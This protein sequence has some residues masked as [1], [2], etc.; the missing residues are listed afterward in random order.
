MITADLDSLVHVATLPASHAYIAVEHALLWSGQLPC[1]VTIHLCSFFD[2]SS[3]MQSPSRGP[4]S[5]VARSTLGDP[6]RLAMEANP[7]KHLGALGSTGLPRLPSS[8]VSEANVAISVRCSQ[9][10]GVRTLQPV[11]CPYQQQRGPFAAPFAPCACGVC[12][13]GKANAQLAFDRALQSH[14][15]ESVRTNHVVAAAI[16]HPSNR[17]SSRKLRMATPFSRP[18]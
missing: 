17:A 9:P 13:F 5:S 7:C 11:S 15:Q 14:Q 10:V 4:L 3:L 6:I 1:L 8:P 2:Q 18:L 12:T 16:L